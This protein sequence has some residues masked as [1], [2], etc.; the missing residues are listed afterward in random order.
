M[1]QVKTFWKVIDSDLKRNNI[2]GFSI[3]KISVNPQFGFEEKQADGY[4]NFCHLFEFNDHQKFSSS[5]FSALTLWSVAHIIYDFEKYNT[6]THLVRYK[7]LSI[8][9]SSPL[10]LML[11]GTSRYWIHISTAIMCEF[12]SGALIEQG[13]W[14]YLDGR[15]CNFDDISQSESRDFWSKVNEHIKNLKVRKWDVMFS[16]PSSA[17]LV[18]RRS[19]DLQG[20]KFIS[21]LLPLS[22][23]AGKQGLITHRYAHY[24]T[25]CWLYTCT[26]NVDSDQFAD[27]L[28]EVWWWW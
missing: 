12:F 13:R 19:N 28:F 8:L 2:T 15:A 27:M 18:R 24:V 14:C 25:I 5:C 21:F 11:I 17:T 6:N 1:L 20:A 26:R 22:K 3:F 9:S 10:D 23:W 4:F 7:Y 16:N